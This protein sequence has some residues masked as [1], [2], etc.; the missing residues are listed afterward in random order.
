MCFNYDSSLTF[1]QHDGK[2][3]PQ[4]TSTLFDSPSIAFSRPLIMP[5]E[6]TTTRKAKGKA[7]SEGGKKKKGNPSH[8]R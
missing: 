2:R 6:K 8:S 5:K 3:Y 1:D 7:A 4:L